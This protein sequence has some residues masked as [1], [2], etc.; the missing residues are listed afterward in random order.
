M[1]IF[2][3]SG[4]MAW[5]AAAPRNPRE[6]CIQAYGHECPC[7]CDGPDIMSKNAVARPGEQWTFAIGCQ[8]VKDKGRAFDGRH[9]ESPDAF[10]QGT[11]LPPRA[12]PGRSVLEF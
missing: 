3:V 7:H 4:D 12:A 2:L 8:P 1:D 9:E 6:A 11:T 10:T 5:N